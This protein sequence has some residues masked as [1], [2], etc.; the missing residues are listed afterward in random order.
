MNNSNRQRVLFPELFCKPVHVSFSREHL[1]SNGGAV[2]LAA[3]DRQMK[4]TE[5]LCQC[6]HDGRQFA[7]VEHDLIEQM[8]QR[9]Y[10]IA[11]G[12]ADGNDAAKLRDDPMVKLA[13]ALD[14]QDEESLA[15]Q[16]TLSRFENG[17]SR[18]ELLRMAYRLAETVLTGQARRRRG[19]RYPRRIIIDLDPTCDPTYGRQQQTFFN[20]YYETWCYLP[21]VVTISFDRE[22]R[23]YPV[24]GLLRPG[25]AGPAAGG[26]AVLR[27]LIALLRRFFPGVQLYCRA[28]SAFANPDFFQYLDGEEIRY[29]V[30]MGSNERLKEM[31]AWWMKIVRR[32]VAIHGRKVTVHRET[33]YQARTWSRPRRLAY[34]AEVVVED[35][36][37]ARDNARF[38]V[39]RMTG[40]YS[41]KGLFDFYYGHSD[42]ENTIKE[43]KNDL[44]MDRTSC[45]RFE[46]NQLRVLMTLTA[47]VLMQSLQEHTSDADLLKAQMATLRDRLLKIAVR[48]SSSVRRIVLD[49]TSHHPW[50][51]QWLNC[52]ISIGAVPT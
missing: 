45:S 3:R 36:K 31:A 9:V 46:A 28:D 38:V 6:L 47:Y 49:F 14:P 40:Q 5:S 15:S 2:L 10:G 43:L 33:T 34:K 21:L 27:R 51:E 11:L 22:D 37:P 1:S 50:A 39:A 52:A 23:K 32:M 44:E 17:V 35:G 48:V 16:P 20:G 13:C 12:C 42:M 30:A 19:R 25:N 7:K 41:A 8:R 18:T 26:L 29:T 24:A 4:L